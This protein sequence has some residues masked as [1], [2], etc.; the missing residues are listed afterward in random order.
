MRS[1]KL[2][3]ENT[4]TPYTSLTSSIF[5]TDRF[6]N[7]VR[8]QST[9]PQPISDVIYDVDNGGWAAANLTED[10]LLGAGYSLGVVVSGHVFG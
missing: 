5:V 2:K 9:G 4:S 7:N 3:Y 6:A 8:I 10:D 1:N